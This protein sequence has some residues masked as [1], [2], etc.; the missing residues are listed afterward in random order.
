VFIEI[1]VAR[2]H[3]MVRRAI[4][5]ALFASVA[6][7]PGC[8][9]TSTESRTWYD[10]GE[11]EYQR[12]GSVESVREVVQR[13]Q[14]NPAG[15]AVA[16]AIIGG[17]LGSAIGGHTHYDRYGYGHHHGNPAGAFVGAIG[18]AA[19]GAAASQGGSEER[20]YEV[21]VRFDDGGYE[22]FTY[23]GASP[24]LPGDAVVLGPKGLIPAQ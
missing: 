12:R 10:R 2:R 7:L 23:R 11:P 6:T 22:T 16:G 8:V 1:A 24:F 17:L 4:A 19:V 20:W 3:T 13:Q 21:Y 18:G 5:L 15:G 9:T 14:G